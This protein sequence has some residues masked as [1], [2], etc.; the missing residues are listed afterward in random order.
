LGRF[1][2]GNGVGGKDFVPRHQAKLMPVFPGPTKAGCFES[3][4]RVTSF[5]QEPL[6]TC[7]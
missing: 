5:L 1:C 4:S 3:T 2:T 7:Y 6:L